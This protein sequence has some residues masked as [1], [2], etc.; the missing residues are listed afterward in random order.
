MMRRSIITTPTT[1]FQSG[2]VILEAQVKIFVYAR[3]AAL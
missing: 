1:T 2:H 3:I